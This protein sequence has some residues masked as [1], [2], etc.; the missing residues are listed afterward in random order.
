M[1]LIVNADDLGANESIND[2]IFALMESGHVTSATIMAGAPGF[3]A[4]AKRAREFPQ[5]SF[6]VHL[7]LTAFPPLIETRRLTPILDGNGCMSRKPFE[8]AISN[9]STK[10]LQHAMLEEL[11]A[12]VQRALDAGIPVSHF[13][14]HHH[15]HTIPKLFPVLKALQRRFGIRRV[16]STINL[17][18][19]ERR[20]TGMRA[21]K[22][23]AFRLA[24]RYAYA[25]RSPQGLGDFR[26]FHAAL[27]GG[28]ILRFVSLDLL[29]H[30]GTT[31]SVYNR[32]VNSLTSD[33]AGTFI[34]HAG[35]SV[36]SH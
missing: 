15:I 11:T 24:L 18:G 30:P 2:A 29:V 34:F 4:A 16:R 31:N 14:S 22:K 33:W 25:T 6:G 36:L 27:L 23:A 13:D 9:A 7:A 5:C 32:E 21:L 35:S 12:Q 17:L 26:D 10:E 20:V 19:P 1:L 8:H 28:A 3:E